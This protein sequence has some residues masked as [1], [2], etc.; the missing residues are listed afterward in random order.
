MSP[1]EAS[2]LLLEAS[3]ILLFAGF[4]EISYQGFLKLTRGE[5]KISQASFLVHPIKAII[6]ALCYL[7]KIPCPS[8]FSE[9]EMSLDELEKYINGK[10]REYEG[11]S[12]IDRWFLAPMP[13]G[14][15][16]EEFLYEITHP[17]VD[18]KGEER[19]KVYDFF[20][21]LHRVI[22]QCYVNRK[23]WH[24]A[25]KWLKVFEDVFDVWKLEPIS[26]VEQEILVFGI[27]TYLHLEDNNNADRFIQRWWEYLENLTN[28]LYLV[29]YFPDLMKRI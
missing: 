9:R 12:G 20:Q 2:P 1:D 5:L 22:S 14:N 23:Q 6:P 8:I 15:W 13:S 24:E 16:S 10:L 27:R 11:M 28:D 4:P 21:D 18:I 17:K 3:T 26:W 25:S 29:A 7:M 19:F